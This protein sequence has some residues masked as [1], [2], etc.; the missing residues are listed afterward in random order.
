MVT[1]NMKATENF[2]KFGHVVFE[3]CERAVTYRHKD[4]LFTILW[5][6]IAKYT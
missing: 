5:R 6:V 2:M 4:M 3:I 1:G